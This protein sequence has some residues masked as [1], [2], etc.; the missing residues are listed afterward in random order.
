[1]TKRDNIHRQDNTNNTNVNNDLYY[2]MG[3]SIHANIDI[4]PKIINGKP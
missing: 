4:I 2:C 3:Y 1:M